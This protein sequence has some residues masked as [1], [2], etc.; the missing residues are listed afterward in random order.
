MTPLL[1]IVGL[2]LLID[3]FIIKLDTSLPILKN[4]I[5]KNIELM[6]NYIELRNVFFKLNPFTLLSKIMVCRNS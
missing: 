6:S 1:K 5:V 3:P 4:S 2:D